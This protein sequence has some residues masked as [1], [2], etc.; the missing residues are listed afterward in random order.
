MC[1]NIGEMINEYKKNHNSKYGYNVINRFSE[2]LSFKYGKGFSK[3]NIERMC[4]FNKI[5]KSN[6]LVKWDQNEKIASL[7]RQSNNILEK[8]F[9]MGYF[10]NI[11]WTHIVESLV[12]NDLKTI[13]K[14]FEEINNKKLTKEETRKLIKSKSIERIISNQKKGEFSNEIEKTLRDPIILNIENKKRSEKELENEIIKNLSNFKKEIGNDIMFYERQYKLNI[15]SLTHKIDLV[16]YDLK[17]NTFLLI[18]LKIGKVTNQ[19]ISQM[20]RYI[21]HFKEERN[22]YRI[23]IVGLILIETKDIRIEKSKNIY[24][25]QYLNEI[26]KEKE[27]LRIIDENKVILLKTESIKEITNK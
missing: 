2:E 25:I 24:Q 17:T 26:P 6:L 3:Q 5:F 22:D 9:I 19:N 14:Y 27:L 11:T 8:L 18:D 20:K 10:T 7:A 16:F 12:L 23:N 21:K 13:L 4:K 1:F 15:N